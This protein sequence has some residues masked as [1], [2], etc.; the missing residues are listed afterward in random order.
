MHMLVRTFPRVVAAAGLTLLLATV[1]ATSAAG[2]QSQPRSARIVN[3]KGMSDAVFAQQWP[4]IVAIIS[5]RASDQY[6]GQYCAGSL[7]DDEHVVTAAHCVVVNPEVSGTQV[8]LAPSA[9]RVVAGT[10]TLSTVSTG[11]GATGARR[12]REIFVHP[13]FAVNNGK[14]FSNDVAVLRLAEPIPGASTIRLVQGGEDA[15]WGNGAGGVDAQVAGWGDTDPLEQGPA[16]S[17]FPTALRSATIPVRSDAL[18][19]ATVGGGYG[20]TFERGTNLCAGTLQS[21]STQLGIDSCQGD[22]GG[23]LVVDAA[24]GSR[25]LAGVVS[26]GEGCAQHSFGAYSRIAALRGWIDGIGGATDGQPAIAGPGGTLGVAYLKRT[27]T[28]WRSVR[29]A[30][31]AADAGTPPER[32]GIWRRTLVSGDTAD[33]LVGITTS[34]HFWAS[35]PP[36]RRTNAYTYVVRPLDS[37]GSAGPSATLRAGPRPDRL[38][39]TVPGTVRVVGRSQTRIAFVWGRSIDRQSGMGRYQVQRRI[40]GRSGWRVM[41]YASNVPGRVTV[42]GLRPG[43]QVQVRVRALDRAGNASV[44]RVSSLLR[45]RG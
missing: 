29:L 42:G 21:S 14:G 30:W 23:P 34:T 38:R 25:R 33:E 12:V 11:S 39:P 31:T 41:A 15:L 7:V 13:G 10:R 37:N 27:T 22:S 16:G 26:W 1:A 17:R 19:S 32:Y 28:T 35:S 24:D 36:T 6:N 5:A 9:I 2:V 40:V 45:T 44:W 43:E 20:T 18:C 3:G 4:F 8:Q